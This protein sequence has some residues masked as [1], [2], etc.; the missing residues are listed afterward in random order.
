MV[1]VTWRDRMSNTIALLR[2]I[3]NARNIIVKNTITGIS[4]SNTGNFIVRNVKLS[5]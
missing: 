2:F 5:S 3:L 4:P 1:L